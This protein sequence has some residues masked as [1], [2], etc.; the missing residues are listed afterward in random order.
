MESE[1]G[2]HGSVAQ[3]S[4]AEVEAIRNLVNEGC[5]G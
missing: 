3:V 4:I 5:L 2:N 1:S